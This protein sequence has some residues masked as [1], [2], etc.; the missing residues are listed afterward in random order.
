MLKILRQ[1]F[2]Q[3]SLSQY[4]ITFF[5][6]IAS[7]IAMGTF[8][9]RAIQGRLRDAKIYM[10]DNVKTYGNVEENMQYEYE[11]YYS[12]QSSIISKERSEQTSLV[13]GGVTGI[14]RKD[15]NS[16]TG[17]TSNSYQAP[18]KNAI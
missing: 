9:Q 16:A 18:T 11:P 3:S 13:V 7:I 14:F 6:A 17:I 2:G 5:L 12:N 8:V 10:I 15:I 1:N 4:V